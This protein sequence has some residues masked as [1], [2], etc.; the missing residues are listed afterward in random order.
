MFAQTFRFG[1]SHFHSRVRS[2]FEPRKPRHRLLRFALGV[3]G[4]GVLAVLVAFSVV[5]GAAMIAIGV[6]YKLWKQRGKRM[7]RNAQHIEG[8]FRVVGQPV[9]EPRRDESQTNAL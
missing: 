8:E 4:L 6:T 9:L 3:I 5:L 7:A 1:T 2:A